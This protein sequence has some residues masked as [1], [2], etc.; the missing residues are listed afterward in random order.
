MGGNIHDMATAGTKL[1]L[2]VVLAICKGCWA[3]TYEDMRY[4]PY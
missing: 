4:I 3:L 2:T 1:V